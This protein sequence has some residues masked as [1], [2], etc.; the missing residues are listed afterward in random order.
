MKP[1]TFNAI[2]ES[3][4]PTGSVSQVSEAI[5]VLT[6]G[7]VARARTYRIGDDGAAETRPRNIAMLACIK[8]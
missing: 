7:S 6:L 3:S 8:T 5:G 2:T 4:A 1:G